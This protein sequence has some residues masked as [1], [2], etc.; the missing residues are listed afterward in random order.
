MAR[1]KYEIMAINFEDV[2]VVP[3]MFHPLDVNCDELS[4]TEEGCR[5]C[6]EEIEAVE[7]ELARI[8][9]DKGREILTLF[10]SNRAND[11]HF[12]EFEIDSRKL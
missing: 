7:D 8:F 4:E 9:K 10:Y 5:W 12:W 6:Q 2:G 1:S 11:D 3:T